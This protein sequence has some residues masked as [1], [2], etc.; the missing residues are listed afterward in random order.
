MCQQP[1]AYHFSKTCT[2]YGDLG[3]HFLFRFDL[4]PVFPRHTS[5]IAVYSIIVVIKNHDNTIATDIYKSTNSHRYLDFRSCHR[6]HTK[7]NVPFNLAQRICK[8][9]SEEQRRD[10]RLE[11]LKTFLISCYY[12]QELINQAINTAKDQNNSFTLKSTEL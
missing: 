2:F 7:V 1:C 10:F 5:S 12:P 3:T 4:I 8:I 11:E 9:V 6:H